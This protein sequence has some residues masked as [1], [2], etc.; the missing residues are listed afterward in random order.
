MIFVGSLTSPQSYILKGNF[1]GSCLV[2]WPSDYADIPLR[3]DPR[4]AKDV[5]THT[6]IF[7]YTVPHWHTKLAE[8]Y[9]YKTVIYISILPRYIL[10]SLPARA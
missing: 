3:D 9:C 10:A 5:L 4:V 6:L 2:L 1:H 8:H 7:V